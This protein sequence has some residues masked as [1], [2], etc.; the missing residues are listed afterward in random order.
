[1]QQQARGR[2]DLN[3]LL[4]LGP[5]RLGGLASSGDLLGGYGGV[6]PLRSL[7]G[8]LNSMNN[9]EAQDP[10]KQFLSLGASQQQQQQGPD[11]RNLPPR[12]HPQQ[13]QPIPRG[14]SPSR[15]ESGGMFGQGQSLP[16]AEYLHSV[17]PP[18]QQQSEPPTPEPGTA[19][20]DPI[21]SLLQQLQSSR[22]ASSTESNSP[23]LA[24]R[25]VSSQKIHTVPETGGGGG[26]SAVANHRHE[27][28]A[29]YSKSVQYEK[30]QVP[31]V[32]SI[33]DN[34]AA[35]PSEDELLQQQPPPPSQPRTNV[36]NSSS[37]NNYEAS[38]SSRLEPSTTASA[39]PAEERTP[40]PDMKLP[41]SSSSSSSVPPA[42]EVEEPAVEV[43]TFVTPKLLE[44]KEK[45]SKK[46]EEKR[47]AKEAR[48]QSEQAGSM[49]YIP[50]MPGS[51]QPEE[52]IVVTQNVL[53]QREEEKWRQQQE[54]QARQ[55]AQV[56]ALAR[57]Q[58]EQRA[59]LRREEAERIRDEKLAKMAP[60]AKKEGPGGAAGQDQMRS[61]TL[62]EIQKLEAEQERI[63]REARELAEAQTREEAR[64]REEEEL[65]RRAAKQS[66]WAQAVL[67]AGSHASQ[68][69][70]LAE[71]QAE[72]ARV[73]REKQERER[74]QRLKE[75]GLAASV[76]AAGRWKGSSGT[77]WAGKIA[78]NA[79]SPA[80][81]RANPPA[82]GSPWSA[83]N[84]TS[85]VNIVAPEG[86]WEPVI[87]PANSKKPQSQQNH[88]QVD[89]NNTNS[90]NTNSNN[91]NNN[92]KK[93]NKKE[94]KQAEKSTTNRLEK[95]EFEDWCAGA[96]VSLQAQVDVPTFLTF[97]RDIESPYEVHDYVKTYVG[98]GKPQK[99]FA[100]EYLERRSRWKNALKSGG[101]YEDDLTTPAMALS[102]GDGD[103]QEAGKKGKKKTKASRS[104]LNHLL[105]FSVQGQGVNRGE[106]DVPQ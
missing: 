21:Q 19:D 53:D 62:Q 96:L 13:H 50:G 72:E 11:M 24:Q 28:F 34:P 17:L 52:Q 94:N 42:P 92:A 26:N 58:E 103:F 29:D 5:L 15:L 102:P 3:K 40:S 60:W 47:R 64:R 23:Q 99:K 49:P 51:V 101:K 82:S 98:D 67:P 79:G 83:V 65:A 16:Q 41:P 73:E 20:F 38:S 71:I 32:P 75:A 4:S 30:P 89:N 36:W 33:W 10:L 81:N 105:G 43:E 22:T 39:S 25:S 1:M 7:L 70:S 77:S 18:S 104:N 85:G 93:K 76:Q 68:V 69:K 55:R 44:K 37:A 9:S 46:A 31:N 12:H 100:M 66:N 106:L 80:A 95:N 35:V 63:E 48:K 27:Y 90:S 54:E 56:E 6:D 88:N 57:L 2:P 86:F 8:S 74:N 87:T 61:L 84:G 14:I 45:K 91:N 97:L 59:R 78:A